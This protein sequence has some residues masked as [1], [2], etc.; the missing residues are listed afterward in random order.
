[1]S[2]KVVCAKTGKTCLSQ[3][4]AGDLIRY[5]KTS[6]FKWNGRGRNIPQRSYYCEYCKTYHLTHFKSRKRSKF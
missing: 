5:F 1:M 2:D 3:K 4:E 6:H